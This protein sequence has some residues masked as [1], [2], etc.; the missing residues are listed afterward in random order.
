MLLSEIPSFTDDDVERARSDTW[1]A[2]RGRKPDAPIRNDRPH[3][4]K[5]MAFAKD[6]IETGSEFEAMRR[7]LARSGQPLQ[8]PADWALNKALYK[9]FEEA[10]E[11]KKVAPAS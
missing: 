9:N 10:R 1:I 8:P 11:Q 5:E 3:I 4:D 6:W 7:E 2:A